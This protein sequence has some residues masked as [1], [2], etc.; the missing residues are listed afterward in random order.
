MLSTFHSQT[1]SNVAWAYATLGIRNI[2]LMD[3][4]A[5]RAMEPRVLSKFKS[6]EVANTVWAF[7]KIAVFK[8]TLLEALSERFGVVA[9]LP[10]IT[11]CAGNVKEVSWSQCG[12]FLH[13]LREIKQMGI[14]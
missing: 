10:V 4:L 1:V 5:E 13:F 11:V 3:A 9:P 2:E 6:Q 12:P 7:A 8:P 14:C